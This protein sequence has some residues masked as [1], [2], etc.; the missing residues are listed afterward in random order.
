MKSKS[1]V[2][3][4]KSSK[5]T[6]CF[7]EVGKYD[8]KETL[9]LPGSSSS[10]SGIPS[11]SKSQSTSKLSRKLPTL[12]LPAE[13]TEVNTKKVEVCPSGTV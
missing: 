9:P 8:I 10:S 11:P 13:E 7:P 4:H 2:D 1:P 12:R 6:T 3:G 5:A